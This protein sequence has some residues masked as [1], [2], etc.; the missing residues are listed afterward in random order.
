MDAGQT[1]W[2]IH[3]AAMKQAKTGTVMKA[4]SIVQY[5]Y[6]CHRLLCNVHNRQVPTAEH[7]P[8]ECVKTNILGGQNVRG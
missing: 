4:C 7:N 8:F 3:A 2:V 6:D 5:S 1:D